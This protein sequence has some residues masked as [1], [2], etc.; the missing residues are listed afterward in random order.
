MTNKKIVFSHSTPLKPRKKAL[1]IGASSGI[2]SALAKRLA[3]EGYNVAC[4]A[5]REALLKA[6]CDEIN[7]QTGEI[8]AAPYIHDVMDYE[9]VPGLLKQVMTDLGGLDLVVYNAG[10][11]FH[12]G[13][14]S[15]NFERNRQVMEINT[16]GAMAWLDAVAPIFKQLKS[17]QIVG[18]GSVAGDRG[19]IGNPAYNSSKAALACYL[20]ALRNRLTRY[21]VHV[22]TAKPGYVDTDMVKSIKRTFW[23]VSAE[24]AADEIWNG[25]RKR[26]QV[27]YISARWRYLMLIIRHIPSIIFRRL[28]F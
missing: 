14:D 13:P 3:R 9:A 16:L 12:D 20:E 26:K 28:S 8:R 21:G 15:W 19:R 6:L 23:V 27:I 2:G 11:I 24:Q 5:R 25:I 1:V 22:M 7:S 17:G 10:I 18:L 4:I